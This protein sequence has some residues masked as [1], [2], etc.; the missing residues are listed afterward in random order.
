MGLKCELE[1]RRKFPC[2]FS[3]SLFEVREFRRG[4]G[5]E[6]WWRNFHVTFSS[7]FF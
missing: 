5:Y 7:V 2:N 3:H 6:F 1:R 4:I